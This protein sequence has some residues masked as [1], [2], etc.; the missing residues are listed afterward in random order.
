MPAEDGQSS[1]ATPTS[2]FVV[3]P[4]LQF[5]ERGIPDPEH[6][7]SGVHRV[8]RILQQR[9]VRVGALPWEPLTDE[10]SEWRDVPCVRAK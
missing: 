10:N 6:G 7:A 4:E 1:H 9:W 3:T 2:D 8:V 5:V